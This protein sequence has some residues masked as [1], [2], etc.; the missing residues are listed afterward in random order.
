M[1]RVSN[2]TDAGRK[3]AAEKTNAIVAERKRKRIEA[4]RKLHQ[5]GKNACGNGEASRSA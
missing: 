5:A 4:V 3:K 2:L 1:P